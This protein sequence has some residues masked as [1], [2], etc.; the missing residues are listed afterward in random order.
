MLKRDHVKQVQQMIDVE[1]VKIKQPE[2]FDSK[3]LENKI[4]GLEK[5]VKELEASVKDLEKVKKTNK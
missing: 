1:V 5:L 4:K 3:P 2:P